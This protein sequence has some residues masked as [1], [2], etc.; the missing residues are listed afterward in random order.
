[1]GLKSKGRLC[2]LSP[3]EAGFVVLK[4]W[5]IIAEEPQN[6]TRRS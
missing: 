1:M 6:K 2:S 4:M 3:I 5:V